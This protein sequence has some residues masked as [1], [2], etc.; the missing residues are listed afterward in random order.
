MCAMRCIRTPLESCR[1]APP[2]DVHLPAKRS[3]GRRPTAQGAG[4]GLGE[5]RNGPHGASPQPGLTPGGSGPPEPGRW[6]S[7]KRGDSAALLRHTCSA[8]AACAK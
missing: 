8:D 4:Q 3:S 5:G 1:A 7:N 2:L 6:F